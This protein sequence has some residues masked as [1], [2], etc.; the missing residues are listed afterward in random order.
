MPVTEEM[1]HALAEENS[2]EWLGV[3]SAGGTYLTRRCFKFQMCLARACVI[4]ELQMR[5]PASVSVECE[6]LDGASGEQFTQATIW[7]TEE[8]RYGDGGL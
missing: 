1:Y 3:R 6:W 5:L 7:L 8:E 4:G 2:G